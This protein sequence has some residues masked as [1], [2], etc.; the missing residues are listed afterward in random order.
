LSNNHDIVLFEIY[1]G[2]YV[3]AE[4]HLTYYYMMYADDAVLDWCHSNINSEYG[5]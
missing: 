2:K 1:I 3:S 4:R 5:M